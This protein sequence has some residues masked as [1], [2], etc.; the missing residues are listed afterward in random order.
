MD[1][2]P[3]HVQMKFFC[4]IPAIQTVALPRRAISSAFIRLAH[5]SRSVMTLDASGRSSGFIL[6]IDL[7]V[8]YC[9]IKR[10]IKYQKQSFICTISSAQLQQHFPLSAYLLNPESYFPKYDDHPFLILFSSPSDP[11]RPDAPQTFLASVTTKNKKAF[12]ND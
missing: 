6:S 10:V 5:S 12:S 7:M 3:P 4:C 8:M 1:L 9:S 2:P 11:E